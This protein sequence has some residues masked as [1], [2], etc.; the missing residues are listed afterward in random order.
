MS[1]QRRQADYAS[2]SAQGPHWQLLAGNAPILDG[3]CARGA[4]V[5]F[6]AT[7]SQPTGAFDEISRNPHN[8]PPMSNSYGRDFRISYDGLLV[9]SNAEGLS[10]PQR[11]YVSVFR[12]GAIEAV[13]LP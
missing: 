9:G 7:G 12:T 1:T 11:A 8:I 5:P 6:N 4:R 3:R 2:E 10:K 13:E